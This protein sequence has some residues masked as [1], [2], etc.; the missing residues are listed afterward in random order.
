M[1][2][3]VKT[4]DEDSVSMTDGNVM[5]Y[6]SK[7]DKSGFVQDAG[8]YAIA[9]KDIHSFAKGVRQLR[10]SMNGRKRKNG[11]AA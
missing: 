10:D 11:G 3:W 5:I 2:K 1:S 4:E 9:F 6:A 8:G 7:F